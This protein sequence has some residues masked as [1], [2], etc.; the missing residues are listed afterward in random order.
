MNMTVKLLVFGGMI[1]LASV[2]FVVVLLPW[3][4]VSEK[5]SEIFR[6]R[7]ALED[8]GRALYIANGCTYCHTQFVRS[9][10]WDIGAERIARTGDYIAE[11]PHLLGSERTGPDLSQEGG[12]HPDDWHTAHYLDPRSVRPESIM[13]S[14]AFLGSERYQGPG[15]LCAVPRLQ[16]CGYQG[17]QAAGMES[18]GDRRI[19]ERSRKECGV[20][21]LHGA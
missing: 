19:R 18:K 3:W 21:P 14:F 13:P 15:R 10:D 7:S 1:I 11:Q 16:G 17:E 4:T 8:K 12:E 2:L 20:A 9:I 5:P 6:P